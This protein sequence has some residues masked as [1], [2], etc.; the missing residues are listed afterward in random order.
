M[1]YC[2]VTLNDNLVELGPRETGKATCLAGYLAAVKAFQLT[3]NLDHDRQPLSI[4]E[5]KS[6]SSRGMS[7][8]ERLVCARPS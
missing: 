1:L 6:I 4:T 8:P 2:F 7:A 5:L 3:V